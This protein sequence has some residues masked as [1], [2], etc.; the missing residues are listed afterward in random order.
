MKVRSK[1]P[2]KQRKF[3]FT[4]PLHLAVNFLN[5]HLSKELR[6]K[7]KKRNVRVRKG[8][9]VKITRG[10][11]S[12]VTGKVTGIGRGVIN[13]EGAV[14]KKMGG[15]ET[16]VPIQASNVVMMQMIERK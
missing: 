11:F 1:Q 15:K 16:P 3:R 10:K 14:V 2:R 8:D 13:V 7:L 9:S 12:G 4:A 6:S 5:V